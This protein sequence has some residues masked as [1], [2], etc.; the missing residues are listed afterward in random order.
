VR[1]AYPSLTV[2][3]APLWVTHD[4]GFFKKNGVDAEMLYIRS[5]TSIQALIAGDID[6][7]GNNGA[8]VAAANL[9]GADLVIIV[10]FIN[11]SIYRV[12]AS[13]GIRS[14]ENLKGKKMAISRLGSA[15]DAAAR[16]VLRKWGLMPDRDV[17]I[18]QIGEEAQRANA[19]RG[20]IVQA[21]ILGDL[22]TSLLEKEGLPVLG[23]LTDLGYRTQFTSMA[24][25]RS[26]IQKNEEKVRRLVQAMAE[27]IIYAFNHKRETV[28]VVMK[29]T[30]LNE[31]EP[32][33]K[34]YDAVSQVWERIPYPTVEGMR[35]D[36]EWVKSRARSSA[37]L[38]AEDM[39]DLRFVRELERD[40]FFRA[41]GR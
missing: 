22:G 12:I 39:V 34:A 36:L 13:K 27:G 3:F 20:G 35:A 31:R 24:T 16:F 37:P 1:L 41:S 14:P 17:A 32:I 38:R 28:D 40:G 21:A 4:R 23:H 10:G 30:K 19:V 25:R 2:N 11:R 9:R 8:T 33:E 29:Y 6:L 5:S 15:T 26:Y 18:I 7:T